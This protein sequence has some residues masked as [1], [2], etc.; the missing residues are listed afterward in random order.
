[1][2]DTPT[3]LQYGGLPSK[4]Q[5]RIKRSLDGRSGTRM[6]RSCNRQRRLETNMG[7]P[8]VELALKTPASLDVDI[9]D[10]FPCYSTAAP[11]ICVLVQPT[12]TECGGPTCT[13]SD[14]STMGG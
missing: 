7:P 4:G 11:F 6:I 12:L 1:M 5:V 3:S 2:L 9:F 14:E 10:G 13:R 8:R